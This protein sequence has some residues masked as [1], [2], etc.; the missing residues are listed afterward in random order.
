MTML[1]R[2]F[3]PAKA[4]RISECE[5]Q[6]AIELLRRLETGEIEHVPFVLMNRTSG[7]LCMAVWGTSVGPLTTFVGC[8]GGWME[9]IKGRELS[10]RCKMAFT[11]VFEADNPDLT[12]AQLAW[13]LRTKLST[14]MADWNN[15]W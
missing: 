6:A 11:D 2:D 8:A 1:A 12:P 5:R 14:G 15:A 4:L 7:G 3:L 13:A 10:E 9:Q